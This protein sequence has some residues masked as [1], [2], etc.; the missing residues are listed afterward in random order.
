MAVALGLVLVALALAAYL[1]IGPAGFGATLQYGVLVP[2]SIIFVCVAVLFSRMLP[3]RSP[4][5]AD[6]GILLAAM[7][8]VETI[9]LAAAMVRLTRAPDLRTRRNILIT[10]VGALSVVPGVGIVSIVL[11]MDRYAG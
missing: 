3:P 8:L 4:W 7:T 10:A 5:I 1:S 11:I 2:A 9:P 6:I